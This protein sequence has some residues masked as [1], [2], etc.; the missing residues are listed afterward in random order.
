MGMFK[1]ARAFWA[2]LVRF[3]YTRWNPMYPGDGV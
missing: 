1:H 2:V 3:S